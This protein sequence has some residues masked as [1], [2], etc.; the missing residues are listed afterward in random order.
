MAKKKAKEQAA[1]VLVLPSGLS[2]LADVAAEHSTRYAIDGIHVAVTDH[3]ACVEAT[4]RR[5]LCRFTLDAPECGDVD[6]LIE[7]DEWRVGMFAKGDGQTVALHFLDDGKVRFDWD[8]R[9]FTATPM[10]G[11][12]PRTEEGILNY[13]DEDSASSY[14]NPKLLGRLLK[15]IAAAIPEIGVETHLTLTI[16]RSG[17]PRP[18]LIAGSQ[19]GSTL[20]V[21]AVIMQ[22]KKW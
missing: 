9:T 21:Q 20:S 3:K 2:T 5:M 11:K 6:V 4:D 10:E 18:L 22:V 12:F 7:R 1:N 15:P 14:L 8:S 13:T 19:P 16:P 17:A